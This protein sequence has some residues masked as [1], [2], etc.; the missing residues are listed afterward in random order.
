MFKY[1]KPFMEVVEFEDEVIT[2]SPGKTSS[3][4]SEV[5]TAVGNGVRSADSVIVDT[6]NTSINTA[7]GDGTL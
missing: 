2:N 5:P 4:S 1:E 6:E 3:T 7:T